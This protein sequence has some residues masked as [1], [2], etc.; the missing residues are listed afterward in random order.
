MPELSFLD[1]VIGLMCTVIA[2][3]TLI[4][5]YTY[6][7]YM[8]VFFYIIDKGSHITFYAVILITCINVCVI[9]LF[10]LLSLQIFLLLFFFE[11]IKHVS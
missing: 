11:T 4:T 10:V 3:V 8:R 6:R 9:R 5:M 2:L 1:S 7:K